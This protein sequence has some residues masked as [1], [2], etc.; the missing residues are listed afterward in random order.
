MRKYFALS[1]FVVF[2]MLLAACSTASTPEV[3]SEP[4]V[5]A[6]E[7]SRQNPCPKMTWKKLL[8][9]EMSKTIVDIAVKDGRFTTLVTALT[10]AGLVDALLAE[11]P[12]TVFAPTDE[13]FAALP[14]GALEGLLADN[15]ALTNVLLYHVVDGK[16]MAADVVGLDGQEVVTLSGDQ[17]LVSA[18][19]MGVMIND[20]NVV[21][22]DIEASNGVIHVVDA[23]IFTEEMV[24]TDDDMMAE[25]KTIV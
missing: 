9:Q 4:A 12:F 17:V 23:V 18:D 5:P 21:I 6:V 8:N 2:A 15:D 20:S 24:E 3:V 25:S 19:D 7:E 13:A 10:E 11:G 1:L 14:E 16:V 22:T